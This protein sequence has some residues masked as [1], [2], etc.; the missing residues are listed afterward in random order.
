MNTGAEATESAL[1]MA[2]KWAYVKK[3]VPE[4]KA[5]IF[6]AAGCFHGRTIASISLSSDAFP[7]DGFGPFVPGM[8]PTV[9]VPGGED[10]QIRFNH[11]EDLERAF[12]LHGK[13]TAAFILEPI[14]GEAGIIVPSDTYLHDVGELCKRHN[15]SSISQSL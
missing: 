3:G 8:G 9:E 14:Q 5:I 2:R 15:V 4:G 1:K 6:S 11:I 10:F 12:E 13:N 7:R